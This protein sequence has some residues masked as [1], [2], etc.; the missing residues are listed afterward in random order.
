MCKTDKLRNG[1]KF[2]NATIFKVLIMLICLIISQ[3]TH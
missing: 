3:Q 2:V 1:Y